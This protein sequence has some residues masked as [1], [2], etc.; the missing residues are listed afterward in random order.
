MSFGG[1][2]GAVSGVNAHKHTNA[3]G[4][5]SNLDNTTLLNAATLVSSS[6]APLDHLT[7]TQA[8]QG[9]SLMANNSIVT[10]ASI[11]IN[12]IEYPIEVLL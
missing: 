11:T 12:S 2:G 9:G 1:G 7:N 5:G 6:F 8:L 3:A 4:D 10:G